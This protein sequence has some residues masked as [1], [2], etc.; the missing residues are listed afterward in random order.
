MRHAYKQMIHNGVSE[1]FELNFNVG[2]L[3]I[4]GKSI[5]IFIR[6]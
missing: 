3:Q 5:T 6:L 2:M 4:S 1:K